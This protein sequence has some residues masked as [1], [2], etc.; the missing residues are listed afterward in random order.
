MALLCVVSF[1]EA[2]SASVLATGRQCLKVEGPTQS[3]HG[4]S[5]ARFY[6]GAI[7]YLR[8]EPAE[9]EHYL[10]DVMRNGDVSAL[11]FVV[12]ASGILGFIRLAQGSPQEAVHIVESVNPC[13]LQM[14]DGFA[15][16]I[17]DALQVE[18][19]LRQG[20]ADEAG[21]LSVRVDFDLR[22]P[23]WF[24]YVPQLTRIKLL[25]AQGTNQS[26]GEAHA[27]LAELDEQMARIH[28]KRVRIDVLALRAM[29]CR[30][31]GDE[32][33]TLEN[34]QTA[35]ALAEPGGW[36]RNFVDLA[37]PMTDLLERLTQIHP[38]H[39]YNQQV[40]N[41]CRAE[42]QRNASPI[43][44]AK[45]RLSLSGQAPVPI[46]TPRETEL[47]SLLAEGLSN[48]EI[49]A[50]LYIATETVKKHLQNIYDKL[51]AGG[52]VGALKAARGLGIIPHN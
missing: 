19:A 34:L 38:A 4:K 31:L 3:I 5:N 48:K 22:P 36:I 8:N 17:R 16:A 13:T 1:L 39:T 37:D 43:Q 50:R 27:R 18:F 24:S 6:M 7:Y 29:V 28:R 9:A 10:T 15:L 49:A 40:L 32:T 14:Q 47:L 20:N 45:K 26:L 51:N 42:A 11:A 12:Q 52:R 46:L 33:A 23:H 25:L 2:D 21:R 41:A 44:A 35:L 30:K